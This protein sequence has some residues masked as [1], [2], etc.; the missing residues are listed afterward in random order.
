MYLSGKVALITGGGRGIGRA[1]ALAYAQVGARVVVTA[2]SQD[3]LE[4]TAAAARRLGGE[5]LALPCDVA[6]PAQVQRLVEE[7]LRTWG[8]VDILVNNAGVSTGPAP[9]AEVKVEEWDRIMAVNLRGLLLCSQAVIPPMRRQG[10]GSI[11]N[12]SSPSGQ[13]AAPMLGAYGVSKWGLEGFTQTL[14]AELAPARI[15]VNAIRPGLIATQMTNYSG[16][17]PEAVTAPFLFLASDMSFFVTG[18]SLDAHTWQS[19]L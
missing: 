6:D 10:G 16:L 12:V 5:A 8:R 4:E 17:P 15:R 13:G 18:R 19:Q 2:R 7:T 11:I 9:L 3:Q 14:A 1:V